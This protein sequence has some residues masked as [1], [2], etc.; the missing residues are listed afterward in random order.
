MNKL[1]IIC[2]ICIL[3]SITDCT[4]CTYIE[5]KHPAYANKSEET[6]K[7]IAIV[8]AYTPY[9]IVINNYEEFITDG[10]TLHYT[11][12]K[13][14]YGEFHGRD[15]GFV[16]FGDCDKPIRM[17]LHFLN[18]PPKCLIFDG[19]IKHDGIDMRSWDSYKKG[20][21]IYL[22]GN[23][24]DRVDMEYVYTITPEHKAMAKEDYC[25]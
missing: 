3:A 19:P 8:E 17:E 14:F 10:D 21:K 4:D 20:N 25:P 24:G 22:E 16:S 9:E 13:W 2:L 7:I 1:K 11:V 12:G 18:N 15:C 5:L 23:W 6:V